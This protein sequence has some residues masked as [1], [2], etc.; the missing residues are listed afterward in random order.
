MAIFSSGRERARPAQG[1]GPVRDNNLSVV[2]PGM[3]IVGE[4]TTDGVVKV[5]GKI[6]GNI[7][8]RQ[9][10][11]VAKGGIV[12]GDLHTREAIVGGKVVGSIFAQ[13]R[14]E[15]QR[16][17]AV[18]GDITAQR[19]LVQE[20]GEVNGH[21]RIGRPSESQRAAETQRP[22]QSSTSAREAAAPVGLNR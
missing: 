11:L 20:G 14:V 18:N 16:G 8:A 10:I 13:E 19:I 12:E 3:R 21:L 7:R 22:V 17:S 1:R 15:V 2:A 4:L 5:E 9:Q 6:E